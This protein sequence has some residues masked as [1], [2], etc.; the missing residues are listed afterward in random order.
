MMPTSAFTL[1][2]F[3]SLRVPGDHVVVVHMLVVLLTVLRVCPHLGKGQ[4]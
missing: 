1:G 2:D 3:Q 4:G